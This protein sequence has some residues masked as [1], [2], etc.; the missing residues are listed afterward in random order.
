[1]DRWL[2][3]KLYST[4]VQCER[5]FAAY[6]LHAVTAAL[7]SFWV[8]SL[9][10]VYVEFM[11]PLLRPQEEGP[12]L[13][14]SSEHRDVEEARRMA[15]GVL[16]HCVSVCLTLLSPF[17]PFISEELWQ[18]VRPLGPGA[19]GPSL[20]LEPFPHSAQLAHWHFPEEERDFPLVQEVI[21][22]ARS[23]RAQCGLTSE[24]P[25]MWVVC[26]PS[27]AHVLRHFAS[28]VWTLS[29]ISNLHICCPEGGEG[30]VSLSSTPPP[31]G[32]LVGVVDHTCQLH[33]HV[34]SGMNVDRQMLQL[35]Q[36]K[37][38]LLP[39]LEEI[40]RRTRSPQYLQKVPEHVRQQ[41]ES[42]MSALQ[43]EV[44]NIEEQLKVLQ[45]AQTAE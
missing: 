18:R 25:E 10:D 33:L 28:A 3:S 12:L 43:Q 8:H 19:A 11:K 30:L 35:S 44:R 40:L 23:L 2:C 45:E 32:S 14:M 27:Q 20:C 9:C 26:S 13:Q 38:K 4:V 39:K 41:M 29:R 37:D 42:K 17:M 24:K 7:F 31:K 36:R 16:Y 1:M 15:C 5:G 21:R 34:Q 6:K 22:V